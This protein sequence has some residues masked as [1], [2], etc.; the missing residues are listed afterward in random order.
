M[1]S[2]TITI[3]CIKNLAELNFMPLTRLLSVFSTWNR[4]RMQNTPTPMTMMNMNDGLMP[5]SVP[6]RATDRI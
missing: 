5:D 3:F 1:S 4:N 2:G 6:V